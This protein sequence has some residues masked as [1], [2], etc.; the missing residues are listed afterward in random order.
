MPYTPAQ[1]KATK[2][3]RAENSE[4]VRVWVNKGEKDKYKALAA[5][6]GKSLNALV[7]E[8]LENEISRT[9]VLSS[10]KE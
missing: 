2:K 10:V 4:Q 6:Q 1:N 9:G 5:S 8:L 3:Y 7:V